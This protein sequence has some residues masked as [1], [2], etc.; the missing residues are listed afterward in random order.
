MMK[1]YLLIFIFILFMIP[2]TSLSYGE[3]TNTETFTVEITAGGDTRQLY[4]YEFS[5]DGRHA[6]LAY[7]P[8]PY[9]GVPYLQY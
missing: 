5:P 8:D 7:G 9:Q 2:F 4:N 1:N 6:Y 3:L